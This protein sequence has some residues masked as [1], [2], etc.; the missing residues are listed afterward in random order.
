MHI[1]AS[2]NDIY[3]YT[4]HTLNRRQNTNFATHVK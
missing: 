3:Y 1:I 2:I 4:D